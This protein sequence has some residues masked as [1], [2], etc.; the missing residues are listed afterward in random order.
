MK[1]D[2][3]QKTFDEPKCIKDYRKNAFNLFEKAPYPLFRHGL[4]ISLRPQTS[5]RD[6]QPNPNPKTNIKVETS[7]CQGIRYFQG[8][9]IG[10]TAKDGEKRIKLFTTKDWA[11]PKEAEKLYTFNQA[12]TNNFLLLHITKEIKKPIIVT[13]EADE[14]PLNTTIFIHAEKNSKATILLRKEGKLH[15]MGE[16]TRI[17]AE[18][19]AHITF[20]SLQ[21][22]SEKTFQVTSRQ[23]ITKNDAEVHFVDASLGSQFTKAHITTNLQG[24]GSSS[25]NTAVYLAR[26]NQRLDLST[27][28]IHTGEHTTSNI[29]T[30][31]VINDQAKALS[32]GL[33]KI[34]KKASGANGYETQDALLLSDQAEADAIPNLEIYNPDVKCSHGSTVGQIDKDTLF[35]LMSRGLNKKQ[36]IQKI[37]EGY[38]TPIYSKFKDEQLATQVQ[39]AVVEAMT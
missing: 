14:G 13:I 30:K 25:T 2:D 4:T 16:E 28:S 21:T 31:G 23:A 33:V 36:A 27:D 9:D 38:F 19:N 6:L 32:R 12:F 18:S 29:V 17:L 15:Y 10:K 35:Y 39:N 5:L 7:N 3:F 11:I 20:A 1:F 8:R 24:K 34:N 26:N 37:V 22:L